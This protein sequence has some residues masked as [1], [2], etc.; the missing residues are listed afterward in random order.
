MEKP[1]PILISDPNKSNEQ[2]NRISIQTHIDYPAN[3]GKYNIEQWTET[4]NSV[5]AAEGFQQR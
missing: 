4:F 5:E 1:S 2:I 3:L